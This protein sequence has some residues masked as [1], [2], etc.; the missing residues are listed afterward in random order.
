MVYREMSVLTPLLAVK[1]VPS[2]NDE[3][4]V[5]GRPMEDRTRLTEE[6][7]IV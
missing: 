6:T 2:S 5:K 4:L 3:D 1:G 7:D